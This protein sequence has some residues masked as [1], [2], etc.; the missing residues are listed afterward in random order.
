MKS[1]NGNISLESSLFGIEFLG[2]IWLTDWLAD[3]CL[4]IN[5]NR[6]D[7]TA[8]NTTIDITIGN[9][10]VTLWKREREAVDWETTLVGGFIEPIFITKDVLGVM[11]R[12]SASVMPLRRKKNI[13]EFILIKMII[14][15]MNTGV[16]V[17]ADIE[18]VFMSGT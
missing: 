2:S 6:V 1:F 17:G 3:R 10:I 16:G 5:A 11:N 7:R 15:W 13:W 12:Y 14:I 9:I 4:R 18:I 8:I